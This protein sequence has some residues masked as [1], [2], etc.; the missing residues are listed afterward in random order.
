MVIWMDIFEECWYQYT[1]VSFR[2]LIKYLSLPACVRSFDHLFARKLVYF[3]GNFNDS[4]RLLVSYYLFPYSASSAAFLM[5]VLSLC[6]AEK[7]AAA[8]KAQ[9]AGSSLLLHL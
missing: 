4:C 3:Q 9:E 1:I 2:K 7:A 6:A 5:R 8:N